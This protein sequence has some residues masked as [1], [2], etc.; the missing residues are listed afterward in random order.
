M[1]SQKLKDLRK[2]HNLTQ[3]ELAKKLNVGTST[4]GM[5]ESSIRRP[6]YEVL[7][8][9]ANY[10]NVTVDYLIDDNNI[11]SLEDI[12][13]LIAFTKNIKKLSP[14]QKEQIQGFINYILNNPPK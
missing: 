2:Q 3:A 6:S 4:I 8:K 14:K 9:I 13:D 5:Y 1:F 12:D 11:E 10:F 7:K